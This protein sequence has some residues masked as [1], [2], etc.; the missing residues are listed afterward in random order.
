MS[1]AKLISK[2]FLV[3]LFFV[4]LPITASV[5]ASNLENIT[6]TG[7]DFLTQPPTEET[8]YTAGGGTVTYTPARNEKMLSSHLKMQQLTGEKPLT[9]RIAIK[10]PRLFSRQEILTWFYSV[11]TKSL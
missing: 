7:I 8:V 1:K 3:S 9:I 4:C 2:L 5:T 10:L 6:E 11:K